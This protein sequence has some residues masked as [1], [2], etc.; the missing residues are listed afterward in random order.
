MSIRQSTHW[1]YRLTKSRKSRLDRTQ[2]DLPMKKG[3]CGT[4]THDYKRNGTTTLF[5]ALDVLEGRVI[6]QCMSRHRHQEFIR[7]LNKINRETPDPMLPLNET[8]Y[9]LT[10]FPEHSVNLLGGMTCVLMLFHLTDL[11]ARDRPCCA[12]RAT[13]ELSRWYCPR[14]RD[15][16]CECGREAFHGVGVA[17]TALGHADPTRRWRWRRLCLPCPQG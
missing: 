10:R 5:A 7:F 13:A 4:M 14:S 9:L 16:R 1:C 15:G 12:T 8:E 17:V 3:R 2:P 11:P 6:G